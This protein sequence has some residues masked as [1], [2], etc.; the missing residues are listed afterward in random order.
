MKR[1]NI[2][3]DFKM[4]RKSKLLTW[5]LIFSFL[6][7]FCMPVFP[8]QVD[9]SGTS[10]ANFLKIGVGARSM[11]MGDATIASVNSPEAMYWNVAAL[12]KIDDD[13]AVTISTMDWLVDT[14]NSYVAAALNLEGVGSFGLDFQFL[15]YGKIEE[16][17]VYDQNGTGRYFSANDL[18][19][20]FGF[21]RKLTD[22]FSFGI[23]MKYINETLANTSADAFAIDVGAVFN[24]TFFNNNLSLAA[25]I[26]NF[27]TKMKF[28]GRDLSI[29]YTVPD[30]PSNKQI[31]ADLSTI[32]WDIPLL[33]RFGISNYFVNN[34]T[35]SVLASYDILDSRD[36]DVRHNVGLELG[37][38]KLFYLRGGYKFNYDEVTYTAGVGLDFSSILDYKINLDYLYL[39]YG[40]FDNLNEF[41]IRINL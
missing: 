11:A 32:E 1:R 19:I 17:T 29:T 4:E 8:Q 9:Y 24:T 30:N 12:T 22:R 16:T 34:D 20:G 7:L 41:T 31:P 3:R 36:Y 15:N 13:F 2:K 39:N 38:D 35:W 25:S 10:A 28:S 40:N 27:G 21:A 33:F 37:I 14:R 5:F 26:A 23:K 6:M 18:S